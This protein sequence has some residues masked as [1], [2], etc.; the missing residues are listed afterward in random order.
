MEQQ[1]FVV[2]PT[3]AVAVATADLVA[4][5]RYLPNFSSVA[6]AVEHTSVTSKEIADL[7]SSS[8]IESPIE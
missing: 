3:M 5:E 4:T 1:L 2:I 6:I 8:A 7:S